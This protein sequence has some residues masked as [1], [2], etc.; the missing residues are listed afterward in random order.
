[1]REHA[2]DEVVEIRFQKRTRSAA[3]GLTLDRA[4][5]ERA[6]DG[7]LFLGG[8]ASSPI[9][10][11]RGLVRRILPIAKC[12]LEDV[13]CASRVASLPSDHEHPGRIHQQRLQA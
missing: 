8:A 5:T 7:G 3:D 10:S 13:F 6:G 1:M 9:G 12:D 11:L 2:G 4:V